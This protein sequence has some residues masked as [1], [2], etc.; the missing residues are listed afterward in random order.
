MLA[1][2]KVGG[3]SN[4]GGNE[5]TGG[6]RRRLEEC[7]AVL[8]NSSKNRVRH[9]CETDEEEKRRKARRVLVATARQGPNRT[10]WLQLYLALIYS[11]T[12]AYSAR[13][14]L[15]RFYVSSQHSKRYSPPPPSSHRSA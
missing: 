4:Q 10:S 13:T 7:Q 11:I 2:G 3:V 9:L 15:Q 14:Y 8:V 1:R 5:D 12:T 6:R